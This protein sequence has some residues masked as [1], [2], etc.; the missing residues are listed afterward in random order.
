[1][2]WMK[3]TSLPPRLSLR[4]LRGSG[5]DPAARLQPADWTDPSAERTGDQDS[6]VSPGD[7]EMTGGAQNFLN[8][9]GQHICLCC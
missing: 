3:S 2:T 5:P 9:I 6:Q 4:P 8:L 7:P 1:M